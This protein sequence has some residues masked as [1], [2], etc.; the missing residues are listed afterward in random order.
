MIRFI[1]FD[2][3]F[4]LHKFA[5]TE[6]PCTILYK[7]EHWNLPDYLPWGVPLTY[8]YLNRF[9]ELLVHKPSEG[10]LLSLLATLLSPVVKFLPIFQFFFFFWGGG[11]GVP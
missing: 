1:V 8:L 6:H 9:S 5:G 7:K 11:G 2:S 3:F 10:F 4:T